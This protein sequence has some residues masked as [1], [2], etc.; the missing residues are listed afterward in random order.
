MLRA[1]FSWRSAVWASSI[2]LIGSIGCQHTTPPALQVS[3]STN[4]SSELIVLCRAD[5]LVY[6][7]HEPV[8]LR[9][10]AHYKDG[11]PA[12]GTV[13]YTWEVKVG[14]LS[15]QGR[16]TQWDLPGKTPGATQGHRYTATVTAK[17]SETQWANCATQVMVD[18]RTASGDAAS[19]PD[20]RTRTRGLLISRT[21]LVG[22]EQLQK[23]YGLYSFIVFTQAPQ[24][25]TERAAMRGLIEAWLKSLQP[26]EVFRE[27]NN[28]GTLNVTYVPITD[29]APDSFP[30]GPNGDPGSLVNWLIDH[31]NYPRAHE[32]LISAG[33]PQT[34][35][36]YLLSFKTA[37][38]TGE[39]VRPR[40]VQDLEGLTEDEGPFWIRWFIEQTAQEDFSDV[41]SWDMIFLKM[42]LFL[43]RGTDVLKVKGFLPKI[44]A[45]FIKPRAPV[46]ELSQQDHH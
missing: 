37:P 43:T 7:D 17:I 46:E 15:S 27:E 13:T 16:T 14:H 10:F 8:T 20:V 35:G 23:D 18:N 33:Q 44:G 22:S 11:S 9:A 6:K 41:R 25:V 4:A 40:L 42:K 30:V 5:R 45:L 1:Q 28:D 31:Y 19:P 32:I 2:W 12:S 26:L 3:P 36:P 39:S 29:S 24:D 21:L 34:G 38:R